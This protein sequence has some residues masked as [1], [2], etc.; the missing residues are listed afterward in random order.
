MSTASIR[1]TIRDLAQAAA[2]FLTLALAA[3]GWGLIFTGGN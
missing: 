1:I 2:F 3:W